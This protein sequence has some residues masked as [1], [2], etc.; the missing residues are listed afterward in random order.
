M[1]SSLFVWGIIASRYLWPALR[2]RQ[3][4]DALRPML[5]V[6]AFRYLGM[7]FL[8]PGVVSS[9]LPHAFAAPAAYGDTIAA[10]LAVLSLLS[11]GNALGVPLAWAFNVWGSLDLLNAFYQVN[12][13]GLEPG[14]FGATYF[15]PTVIVPL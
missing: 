11:L 1:A 9:D 10:V 14:Q 2:A 15:I 7:A 3:R 12:A 8:V 5:I 4:A 13:T 6:H